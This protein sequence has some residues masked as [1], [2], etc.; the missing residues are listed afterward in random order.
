ME[1]VRESWTDERLDELSQGV[2]EGFREMKCD[3]RSE[4][5][6]VRQEIGA[7][8]GETRAE[9]RSVRDEI[10]SVRQEIG[11]VRDEIGALRGE[12][13]PLQRAIVYGFVG[14]GAAMITA[15]AGLIATQL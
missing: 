2:T 8:R 14:L 4:I 7:L 9:I 3:L 12:F 13:A 11:S 15:M 6:S 5:G 10:G 1:S